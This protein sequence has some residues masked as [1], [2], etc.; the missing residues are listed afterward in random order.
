MKPDPTKEQLEI[1]LAPN[2]S[3]EMHNPRSASLLSGS[4]QEIPSISQPGQNGVS[5]R[6]PRERESNEL[7]FG[8]E[9]RKMPL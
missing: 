9:V 1:P 5:W 7:V 3:P 8:R 4:A 6:S 2:W